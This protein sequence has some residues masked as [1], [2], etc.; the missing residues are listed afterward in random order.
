MKEKKNERTK[1]KRSTRREYKVRFEMHPAVINHQ[2]DNYI[3]QCKAIQDS[4]GSRGV[5]D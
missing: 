1:E 2:V 3:V 5:L 4:L